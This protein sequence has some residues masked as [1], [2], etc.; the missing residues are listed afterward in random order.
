[1][2]LK[3]FGGGCIALGIL[4]FLAALAQPATVADTS[5]TCIDTWSYGQ[6]CSTV[7]YERPN[8]AR[9]QLFGAGV[10]STFLGLFVYGIGASRSGGASGSSTGGPTRPPSG[11]ESR[12]GSPGSQSDG[13][14]NPTDG[15]ER[16]AGGTGGG[17]P[18]TLRAE[19]EARTADRSEPATAPPDRP[20][21]AGTDVETDPGSAAADPTRSSAGNRRLA[22]AAAVAASGLASAF[23]LTWLV[24]LVATVESGV[25]RTLAFAAFALPGIALYGRYRT[26]DPVDGAPDEG[27]A[28][29]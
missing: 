12:T 15:P 14:E 28:V 10:F 6:E 16:R 22:P 2:N 29:Q 17:D 8:Y 9:S 25:V 19:L 7:Q 11:S 18:K 27:E 13:P 21:S 24:D 5:T 4:L 1:M 3:Y 23:A 26:D 20:A